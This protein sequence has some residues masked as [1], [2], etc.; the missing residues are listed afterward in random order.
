M[1]LGFLFFRHALDGAPS[2]RE[3]GGWGGFKMS[4]SSYMLKIP[5][6][7]IKKNQERFPGLKPYEIECRLILES[8][9]DAD[10]ARPFV[11]KYRA[12]I[13]TLHWLATK[14]RKIKEAGKLCQVCG[15]KKKLQVHHINYRNL[16]DVTMDD[17]KALCEDCHNK[18]HEFS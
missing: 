7:E 12:Y 11:K 4:Y 1:V 6:E 5:Y 10:P 16:Y 17:L 9:I 14:T 3:G 15:I 2:R 13:R 18:E 8:I